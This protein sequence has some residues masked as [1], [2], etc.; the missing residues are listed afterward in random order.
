MVPSGLTV[1]GWHGAQERASAPAGSA[2]WAVGG[3]PWQLPQKAWLPST[4]VQI[5]EPTAPPP[6]PGPAPWQ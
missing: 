2:G 3:S 1:P 6:M 5:G 4:R